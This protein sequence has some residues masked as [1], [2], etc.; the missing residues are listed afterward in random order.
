MR[1][2]V[3]ETPHEEVAA[4]RAWARI[5]SHVRAHGTE[6]LVLPEFAFLPPVWHQ[7]HFDAAQWAALEQQA[8]AWCARLPELGCRHVMGAA[9]VTLNGQPRNQGF[10]WSAQGLQW[11][12]G[13]HHLPEEPGGWEAR[14]FSRG[15][16]GFPVFSAGALRFGLNICTELWALDTLGPY[17]QA[18]VQA[19]VSPR[20]TA[21]ATTARWLSLAQTVAVRLGAYSLS[22][23]R[24]HADGSC[25]GVGWIIDPEGQVVARTSAR[26][27]VVTA[28]ID[29]QAC[30]AARLRYPR[31]VFADAAGGAAPS[32][33]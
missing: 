21:A 33:S 15:T 29:L 23:N 11:L 2:T 26:V 17:A 3:C 16:E 22:S 5:R 9:P 12:R 24:R 6:L 7:A 28:D 4:R 19:V 13:K 8:A 32:S 20:A 31:Y 27:P 18:G 1:V 30:Q 25:G 14:W 10:L